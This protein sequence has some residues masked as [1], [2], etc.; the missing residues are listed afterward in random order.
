MASL[1]SEAL[2]AC[3]RNETQAAY[4]FFNQALEAAK[5]AGDL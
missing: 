2:S 3:K 5:A 4:Q 1:L